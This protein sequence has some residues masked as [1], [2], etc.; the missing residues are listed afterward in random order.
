MLL[1]WNTVTNAHKR[2]SKFFRS[3][4]LTSPPPN[5]ESS[6]LQN[7]HPKR[8]IPRILKKEIRSKVKVLM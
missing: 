2:E 3:H 8:F 1:T 4:R 7:L 6:V 5:G